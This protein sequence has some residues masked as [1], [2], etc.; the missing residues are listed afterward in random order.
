MFDIQKQYLLKL[1]TLT[2]SI[3]IGGGGWF[4]MV[5]DSDMLCGKFHMSA[6]FAG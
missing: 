2:M 4:S 1:V 6:K 3:K 5:A